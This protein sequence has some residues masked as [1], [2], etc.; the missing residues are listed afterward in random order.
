VIDSVEEFFEIEIDHD[1]VALG[2]V[3]LRLGH[4]LVGRSPRSEAIAVLG[5][6]HYTSDTT[7]TKKHHGYPLPV[8]LPRKCNM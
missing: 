1:V 7:R 6:V 3:S 5:H 4:R 8:P 2:D